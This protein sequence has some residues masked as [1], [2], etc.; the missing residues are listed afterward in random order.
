MTDWW[1]W[2]DPTLTCDITCIAIAY[3]Q[4]MK[5]LMNNEENTLDLLLD[6]NLLFANNPIYKNEL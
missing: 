4:G 5:A 2:T 6:E 1:L 3:P